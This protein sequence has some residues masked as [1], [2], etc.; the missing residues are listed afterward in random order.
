MLKIELVPDLSH[1]VETVAKREFTDAMSKLLSEAEADE[2]L[3]ERAELLRQFLETADFKRLRRES[4]EQ[5]VEGKKVTFVVY[6]EQ[7]APTHDMHVA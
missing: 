6:L 4:E 2:A 3:Q 7:G 5:L 1:C